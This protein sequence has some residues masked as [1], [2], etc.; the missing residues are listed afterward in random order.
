MSADNIEKIIDGRK[1]YVSFTSD[2]AYPFFFSIPKKIVIFGDCA[3]THGKIG[4]IRY[5]KE[6]NE[7]LKIRECQPF[8]KGRIW[9]NEKIISFWNYD[10]A[11]L[12]DIEEKK[13]KFENIT[14]SNTLTFMETI[15]IIEDSFNELVDNNRK[16]TDEEK[17]DNPNLRGEWLYHKDNSHKEKL[18][19]KIHIDNSWFIDVP[20]KWFG[21]E[22]ENYEVY[23]I[24]YSLLPLN[25]FIKVALK[26]IDTIGSE[27]LRTIHLLN[28]KEKQEL[29]KKG[30]G[31]GW[32]S[33]L[34]AWDGKN[35][36]WWRQLKYQ[37]NKIY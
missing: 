10:F 29:K 28:Y 22:G 8:L 27:K 30:W 9:I 26:N 33:D 6:Y 20:V 1:Q 37:E 34:T 25:K 24:K 5:P 31:R 35:P 12:I 18:D 14:E 13:L 36:L 2:G 21:D 11:D 23:D 15:K 17:E 32:G 3:D 7:I 19:K 4:F 16:L